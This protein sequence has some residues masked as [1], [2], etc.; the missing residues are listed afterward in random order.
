M[1]AILALLEAEVTKMLSHDYTGSEA[2]RAIRRARAE[3]AE[4][5]KR[6]PAAQVVRPMEAA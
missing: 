6:K 3:V 5:M 2:I 4:A 1:D